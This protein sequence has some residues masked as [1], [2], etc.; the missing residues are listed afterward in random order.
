MPGRSK[1]FS[2]RTKLAWALI[3]ATLLP[4][5]SAYLVG[6]TLTLGRIEAAVEE[7]TRKTA[8]IARNVLLRQV[9]QVSRQAVLISEDMELQR[10]LSARPA[11]APGEE[12]KGVEVSQYLKAVYG[13]LDIG[14]VE[15]VRSDGAIAGRLSRHRIPLAVERL[16]VKPRS[17]AIIKA[18]DYEKFVTLRKIANRLVIR[19]AVPV[20]DKEYA[21]VGAVVL[22][23]PLDEEMADFIKGV[24]RAEIGFV[25]DNDPLAS[26]FVDPKGVRLPGQALPP[27]LAWQV[28]TK[29]VV[30]SKQE[31]G[32]KDYGISYAPLQSVEGAFVGMICVGVSLQEF[33]HAR[34]SAAGFLAL[35]ALGGL[36]FALFMASLVGHRITTPLARLHR[37]AHADADGDLDQDTPAETEDEIGDLA[38]AFQTMTAALRKHRQWQ[39]RHQ[40]ELEEEVHKRTAELAEAN[41]RLELLARTDGLT[42]LYNHRYFQE[43]LVKE[44][45]RCHRSS[46]PLSM[47]MIDVDYFKHYNDQNGHVAGDEVLRQVAEVLTRGRRINDVVARYG[48]EEFSLLLPGTPVN[49]ALNLASQIRSKIAEEPVKNEEAQ[50]GGRLTISVGVASCPEHAATP[51]SL[52]AA[53]DKAL[54]AAKRAGRDRVELARKPAQEE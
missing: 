49:S 35:G 27:D 15:V 42:G 4:L 39:L 10:L 29:Q 12:C 52:V 21:V 5:V 32:G 28:Q 30:Y 13:S 53:A 50:P 36:F 2:L 47:L 6:L 34:T 16:A 54:Y 48:G 25:V 9:Q 14:L 18:L 7:R 45:E 17:P 31:I 3:L 8:D 38:H 1:H 19:V 20:V 37:S 33:N 40:E 43:Y 26:T 46:I 41:E 24:V 22:T 23:L 11:C 51:D 44:V